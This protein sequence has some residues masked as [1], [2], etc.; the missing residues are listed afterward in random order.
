MVGRLWMNAA[1][2]SL[3]HAP[4]SGRDVS[5]LEQSFGLTL[6]QLVAAARANSLL[7]H[8]LPNGLQLCLQA[9]TEQRSAHPALSLPTPLAVPAAAAAQAPAAARPDE[10]AKLREANLHLIETTLA[11]GG[12]NMSRAARIGRVARPDLPPAEAG[13]EGTLTVP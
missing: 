1:G 6:P 9:Q 4:Q 13:Q 8:R 3:L 12:G 5:T 10:G 7:R 11:A 2:K